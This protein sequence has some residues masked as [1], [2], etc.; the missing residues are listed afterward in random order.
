[1]TAGAVFDIGGTR[2]RAA[3]FDL[4]K[5]GETSGVL[6]AP[7][8]N[9][10][11]FPDLLPGQLKRRL[12]VQMDAFLRD[13]QRQR[14]VS[15]FSV[16]IAGPVGADGVVHRAPSLWGTDRTPV[17]L[18][19]ILQKRWALPGRVVNDVTAAAHCF[20]QDMRY[21]RYARFGVWTVSTGLGLKIYDRASQSCLMGPTGLGGEIGHLP[22]GGGSSS[23]PC[24][25]GKTGHLNCISSGRGIP[26]LALA[27]AEASPEV[28]R[29][30]VLSE[31]DLKDKSFL[32]RVVSA[33]R[34]PF[35]RLFVEETTRPLAHVIHGLVL[36]LGIEKFIFMGGVA[37]TLGPL[38]RE[39]L[40]SHLRRS[41]IYG[42]SA[43]DLERLIDLAPPRD[44]F[45]LRGAGVL[46][47]LFFGKPGRI[48]P[49]R[50]G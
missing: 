8:P 26:S 41:G 11:L 27:L 45:G 28:F 36:S 10:L 23:V 18:Q 38:Y 16:A 34:D 24:S 47:E 50:G 19:K 6:V 12:L 9:R 33:P 43:R 29:R 21:A 25:C 48:A 49:R 22:W 20:A 32:R 1:M 2:L 46:G 31:N 4:S 42:R 3:L 7:T 44:D 35:S 30:S 39:A 17:P 15:W 5:M 40:A 14:K 37:R 13:L